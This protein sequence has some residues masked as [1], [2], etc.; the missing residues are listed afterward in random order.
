MRRNPSIGLLVVTSF[1]AAA[2]RGDTIDD[3]R[4]GYAAAAPKIQSAYANVSIEGTYTQFTPAG[5]PAM[6]CDLS[7]CVAG[8]RFSKTM[9]ATIDAGPDFPAGSMWAELGTP[10]LWLSA[11]RPPTE[12]DFKF[13]RYGKPDLQKLS[14]YRQARLIAAAGPYCVLGMRV[15]DLLH[16]PTWTLQSAEAITINGEQ[17]VKVRFVN[18][19]ADPKVRTRSIEIF[20]DP[21]DW[22]VTA[23]T[24]D[25]GSSQ[26]HGQIE[27]DDRAAFPRPVKSA[28]TWTRAAGKAEKLNRTRMEA[29]RYEFGV[30][31]AD[32]FSL[33]G[34]GVNTLPPA[35][36]MK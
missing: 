21:T 31:P 17:R 30:P 14:E 18:A 20:F 23:Y 9:V 29:T 13:S 35:G 11:T 32:R 26:S 15:D 19:G 34:L 22:C 36:M 4:A 7:L 33:Q 8:D 28:E 2:A 5:N 6:R 3:F 1:A 24:V 16:S 10:D 25:F 12:F 27:Y